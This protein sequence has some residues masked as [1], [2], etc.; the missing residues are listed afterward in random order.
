MDLKRNNQD[1]IE[2]QTF[3]FFFTTFGSTD[4]E[5]RVITAIT[6]ITVVKCLLLHHLRLI[7]YTYFKELPK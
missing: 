5:K 1:V 3:N 2:L 7:I 6:A 4:H